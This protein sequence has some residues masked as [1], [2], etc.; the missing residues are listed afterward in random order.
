MK[1]FLRF[2]FF[3]SMLLTT[4]ALYAQKTPQWFLQ[5]IIPEDSVDSGHLYFSDS[6]HGYFLG[7]KVLSPT[8]CKQTVFYRTVNGGLT[9]LKV[10][11]ASVYGNELSNYES[12][13]AYAVQFA[14]IP[15]SS[16]CVITNMYQ[17]SGG[18]GWVFADHDT[19]RFYWSENYGAT[20]YKHQT[21]PVVTRSDFAF[22][23]I[24]H[25]HDV[26]ALKVFDGSNDQSKIKDYGKLA[27]SQ[28]YGVDLSYD[29][30]W[31]STLMKNL[32]EGGFNYKKD[33]PL[34]INEHNFDYF[35]D[36]TWIIT[37]SDSNNAPGVADPKRPYSLVTLLSQDAGHSW[38]AYRNII[39]RFP[40]FRAGTLFTIQCIRNTSWVYLFAD[41]YPAF[42][43]NYVYSSNYGKTWNQD[44]SFGANRKAYTAVTPAEVWNTATP[45]DSVTDITPAS[46]VV[47]TKDDGKHW[48]IDS[49]S[50]YNDGFYDGRDIAFT[51]PT[52]GWIFAQRM[53]RHNVAIFKYSPTKDAVTLDNFLFSSAKYIPYKIYPN[54]VSNETSI[55]FTDD[56]PIL[57]IEFFD[58]LGRK[59]T[60]PYEISG[61]T[62]AHIHTEGLRTGCYMARVTQEF[63]SYVVPFVVQH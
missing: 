2:P 58:V 24:P 17:K 31:D 27:Y 16:A 61:E 38:Q 62:L 41:G 8:S 10:D 63:G 25:D 22:E 46:W 35:D 53:D 45:H 49:V 56:V 51:D 21:I 29:L 57:N 59:W 9:W 42:N 28:T 54:P 34:K 12:T 48:D 50:L 1:N 30:R 32:S 6:L 43:V 13:D 60:C 15:H 33:E 14:A 20:W 36:S 3:V 52:H 44:T 4:N 5:T 47:H 55:Q 39:P 7:W 19:L 18:G 37:V 40:S 23:A 26:I 11:Y